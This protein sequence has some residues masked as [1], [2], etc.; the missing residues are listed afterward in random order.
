VISAED[1]ETAPVTS[2]IVGTFVSLENPMTDGV[3]FSPMRMA[4]EDDGPSEAGS[5]MVRDGVSGGAEDESEREADD[6]ILRVG[7][8]TSELEAALEDEGTGVYS[9]G[10]VDELGLT[11]LE[12]V[13]GELDGTS[14]EVIDK[15]GSVTTSVAEDEGTSMVR[16]TL[17]LLT[18]EE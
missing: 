16:L 15:V 8:V 5:V 17:E 12:S 10:Y 4:V 13:S 2:E 18:S 9:F 6:P 3:E 11:E 1:I 7:S 14:E